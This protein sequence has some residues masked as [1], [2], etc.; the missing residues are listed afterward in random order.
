M[1]YNCALWACFWIQS[2]PDSTVLLKRDKFGSSGAYWFWSGNK[3]KVEKPICGIF[4]IS[5]LSTPCE[6]SKAGPILLLCRRVGVETQRPLICTP[7][8]SKPPSRFFCA[9]LSLR[10]SA[11]SLISCFLVKAGDTLRRRAPG[12]GD[13][14]GPGGAAGPGGG[15]GK[16]KSLGQPVQKNPPFL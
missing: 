15:G 14:P 3:L 7:T 13:G 10:F 1:P 12:T 5:W 2:I 11:R 4:E 9:R 8:C 6:P 16:G